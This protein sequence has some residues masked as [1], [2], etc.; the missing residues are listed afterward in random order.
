MTIENI[1]IPLYLS[2]LSSR[3]FRPAAR[4]KGKIS[5]GRPAFPGISSENII[6]I[7]RV[8]PREGTGAELKAP[9]GISG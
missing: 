6:G 9:A 4:Q 5:P 3:N 2:N 7:Y 8:A 1:A